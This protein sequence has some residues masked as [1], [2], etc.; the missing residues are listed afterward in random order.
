MT[1]K[2][3]FHNSTDWKEKVLIVEFLH[4][5]MCTRDE[6]WH[7]VSTAKY[8]NVST[9]L[10]SEDLK[11]ARMVRNGIVNACSSRDKALKFLKSLK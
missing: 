11:L 2:E 7:L 6:N 3:R 1:H 9:A 10:V 5:L 8:F 4:L